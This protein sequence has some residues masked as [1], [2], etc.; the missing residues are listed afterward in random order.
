MKFYSI[1]LFASII[2]MIHGA[3]S[4]QI[5]RLGN[6]MQPEVHATGLIPMITG[7][8]VPESE[9]EIEAPIYDQ[10]EVDKVKGL[11]KETAENGRHPEKFTN[12]SSVQLLE[13][14]GETTTTPPALSTTPR[15]I[16]TLP[17]GILT[18]STGYSTVTSTSKSH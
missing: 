3:P 6:S 13:G 10:H 8:N 11:V 2:S 1:L 5:G 14:L 15:S 16:F 4:P 12:E 17:N 7:T 18:V 9:E